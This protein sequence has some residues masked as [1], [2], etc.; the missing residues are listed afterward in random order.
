MST[1]CASSRQRII[2][3]PRPLAGFFQERLS[4]MYAGRPDVEVVVDRRAQER[5][6]AAPSVP[7]LPERRKA[8]RRA[9]DVYWSLGDMPFTAAVGD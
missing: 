1:T 6:R 8:D 2:V 4:H 7:H 5:R 9:S 3:V